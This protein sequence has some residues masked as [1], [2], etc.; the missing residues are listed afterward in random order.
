MPEITMPNILCP[1]LGEME[2]PKTT[3]PREGL[4]HWWPGGGAATPAK[5]HQLSAFLLANATK[6]IRGKMPEQPAVYQMRC[7]VAST[8]MAQFESESRSR[9]QTHIV[10]DG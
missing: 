4:H 6:N 5:L 10:A 2:G 3:R 8:I 7:V 9:T 1:S